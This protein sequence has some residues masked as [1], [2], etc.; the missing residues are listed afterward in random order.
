MAKQ[1]HQ[2]MVHQEKELGF[3]VELEKRYGMINSFMT[4]LKDDREYTDQEITEIRKKVW[5]LDRLRQKDVGTSLVNSYLK[6]YSQEQDK[7]LSQVKNTLQDSRDPKV[8]EL[9]DILDGKGNP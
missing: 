3:G 7:N 9:I 6:N 8:R 4:M 5:E 2:W 1:V